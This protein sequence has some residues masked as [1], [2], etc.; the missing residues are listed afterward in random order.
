[1]AMKDPGPRDSEVVLVPEIVMP[2]TIR[3]LTPEDLPSCAWSGSGT[4]L[5]SIGQALERAKLG[6]VEYLA[7]CPPSG[8]PVAHPGLRA[9]PG[10]AGRRG[11]QPAGA[12]ALRETRLPCLR[13]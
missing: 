6:E 12:H 10:R 5:A 9:A 4:H 13:S 1:M 7:A 8:L 3:D 11:Q 2:L